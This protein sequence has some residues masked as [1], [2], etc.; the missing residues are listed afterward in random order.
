MALNTCELWWFKGIK[1][2]SFFTKNYKKLRCGWGLSPQTTP[3][4]L[5]VMGLSYTIV[6]STHL[7]IYT[8]ALLIFGLSLLPIAKSWLRANTQATA[9]ISQSTTSLS[10]KK[11]VFQKFLKTSLL[12]IWTFHLKILTTPMSLVVNP[13][14]QLVTFKTKQKSFRN[15]FE[16][17]IIYH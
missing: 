14:L 17:I 16:W 13:L 11:F 7:L 6:Y 5:S 10:H 8:F 12:V 9:S 3:W 2:A 1:I 15:F 4:P